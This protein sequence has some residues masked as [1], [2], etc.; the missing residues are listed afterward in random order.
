MTDFLSLKAACEAGSAITATVI[1]EFLMYF[2]AQ[3]EG[4]EKEF[5]QRL[6]RFRQTARSLPES[7][8]NLLRAQYACHRI[9]KKGGFIKKYLAHAAIKGLDSAEQEY[10]NKQSVHPWLFSFHTVTE[11]PYPDF[12]AIEDVFTGEDRMLHSP[13][14]TKI[15]AERR[16]KLWFNLL[17]FNGSCWETFGPVIGYNSFDSDDIFYFATEI[18]P[19]IASEEDLMK[20]VEDNPV[21]YMM[22]VS[23]STIPAL[24]HEDYEI[25]HISSIFELESLSPDALGELNLERRGNIVRIQ[26]PEAVAFPHFAFAYFDKSKKS[27]FI[28]AMTE[29]GYLGLSEQ[30]IR[31]GLIPEHEPDVRVHMTLVATLN[32]ILGKDVQLDPYEHLFVSKPSPASKTAMKK[33]NHFLQ[34]VLPYINSGQQPDVDALAREAGVDPMEAREMLESAMERFDY[35]KT[36]DFKIKK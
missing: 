16:V 31:R 2:V 36:K 20:T 25:I 15:L 32:D 9:F 28:T 1:D 21:P 30:L 10:L 8:V 3:K 4:L 33:M 24:M 29:H 23:G 7:S 26:L 35:L 22:L 19:D 11:S 5:N 18:H 34:L 12:F 6:D 13:S 27:L 17:A 14:M